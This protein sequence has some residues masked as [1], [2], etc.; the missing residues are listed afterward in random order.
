MISKNRMEVGRRIGQIS[1]IGCG[2]MSERSSA[3]PESKDKKGMSEER[4]GERY[5]PMP[6]ISHAMRRALFVS[7]CLSLLKVDM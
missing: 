6:A 5:G 1:A 7:D 3:R 2:G 4:I